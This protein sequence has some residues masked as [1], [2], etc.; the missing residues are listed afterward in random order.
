MHATSFRGHWPTG[1]TLI[2]GDKETAIQV[3]EFRDVGVNVF[4]L[5]T[6]IFKV[7]WPFVR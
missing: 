7:M 6:S 3:S 4:G 5:K 1:L 2:K